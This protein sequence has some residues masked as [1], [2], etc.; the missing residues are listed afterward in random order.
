[1]TISLAPAFASLRCTSQLQ[2]RRPL[3]PAGSGKN[4]TADPRSR[5]PVWR[6]QQSRLRARPCRNPVNGSALKIN[7][8]GLQSIEFVGNVAYSSNRLKDII[9]TR[10][11]NLL[12]ILGGADG[13]AGTGLAG[14]YST[15]QS[16]P[17]EPRVR[18]RINGAS[19][20][21]TWR[22]DFPQ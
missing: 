5:V 19:G 8:T 2:S 7:K 17:M 16:P 14:R 1:M 11:S 10:E 20:G 4:R 21:W 18:L 6:I 9:K 12:S 13:G 3:V 15:V 22:A